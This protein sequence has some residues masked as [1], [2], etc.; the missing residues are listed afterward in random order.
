MKG[1]EAE[2]ATPKD[3][4]FHP[5]TV[6]DRNVKLESCELLIPNAIRISIAV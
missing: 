1:S 4:I 5:R 2:S 3:Q 6:P